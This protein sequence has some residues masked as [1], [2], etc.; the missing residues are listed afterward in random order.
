MKVLTL[1]LAVLLTSSIVFA[2]TLQSVDMTHDD[3]DRS[4]EFYVPNSY[5][6]E[7]ET[8]LVV[9]LHGK[10]QTGSAMAQSTTMRRVADEHGF[11]LLYPDGIQNQWN[12]VLDVP[13]YYSESETQRLDDLAFLQAIIDELD[14][15]YNIDRNRMY[16]AGLSNGGFMTHR[17][18]CTGSDTFAAFASVAATAFTG[19]ETLCEGANP[20][21]FMLIHGT[22]DTIVPWNGHVMGE[23][24][25]FPIYSNAPAI[26]TAGFWN[27]FNQCE[28]EIT[29]EMLPELGDSE[30]T[31][32][33]L[34]QST[35]CQGR[36]AFVFYAVIG[37]GHTWPGIV[38]DGMSHIVGPTNM[39]FNADEAIWDFFTQH[40]LEDGS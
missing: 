4:Y 9:M 39:D 14:A 24:D 10:T 21:P 40:S 27:D 8:P 32:A 28:G 36:G 6:S 26:G 5:D 17:L 1:C 22:Q 2:Q 12:Y 34:I 19:L 18:A 13:F 29:E 15:D 3:F 37:G 38:W 16:V 35:D 30:G 20:I 33:Q 7:T 23:A 31:R 11:L 25:G